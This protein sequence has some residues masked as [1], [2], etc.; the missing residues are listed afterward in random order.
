MTAGTLIDAGPLV[1]IL[2][3]DDKDHSLCVDA[4]ET[5]REPLF[6]T[7]MPITEAMYLL[8]F[9]SRAQGALLEMIQRRALHD[10]RHGA[11]RHPGLRRA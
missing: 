11:K 10:E 2:H 7:W 3:R 1:A 6:S 8:N 4:L 9:S 5:F